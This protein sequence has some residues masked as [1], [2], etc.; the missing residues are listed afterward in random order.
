[1]W[2]CREGGGTV[3]GIPGGAGPQP[4]PTRIQCPLE[5]MRPHA[6]SQRAS[7]YNCGLSEFGHCGDGN[8]ASAEACLVGVSEGT[9]LRQA[10]LPLD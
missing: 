9:G 3:F 5:V 4:R 2:G 10:P 8:A 6:V 7:H 1:M